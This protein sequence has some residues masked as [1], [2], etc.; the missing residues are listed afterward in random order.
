[1]YQVAY[2]EGGKRAVCPD[3]EGFGTLANEHLDTGH[4]G[5]ATLLCHL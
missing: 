1:M 3:A 4:N 5:G 2:G